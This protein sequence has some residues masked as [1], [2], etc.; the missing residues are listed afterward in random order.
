[1]SLE[2]AYAARQAAIVLLALDKGEAAQVMKSLSSDCL[3]KIT[4]SIWAL[5]DVK[6][7]EKTEALANLTIR[8][9]SNPVVGGEDKAHLLLV[10]VVGEEQAKKIIEKAKKEES[11]R[12]AFRSLLTV[13]SSDLA[14]F[15]IKE[16]PSTIA[17]ILGFLPPEKMAEILEAMDDEDL[18]IEII[19][20]LAS[21]TP[22]KQDTITRIE[23]VFIRDIVSKI[24]SKE[25][26]DERQIGGPKVVA[27]ILQN[28]EKEIGDQ[29]LGAIQDH[30]PDLAAEISNQLFTFED[31]INMSDS[32]M[33]RIMRDVPMD[34]L[35][36]AV[37]GVDPELYNKFAENL[38]KRAKE[39]LAEELEL[40]GKVK[41]SE[42]IAVQR[43]IV[44]LVRSLEAAG[45][46]TINM[47]GGDDE[48]I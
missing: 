6:E 28:S 10:E 14:N 20:K 26:K 37:K 8:L 15:L 45:E 5:D 38:S 2:Q 34:K 42:V 19:L 17:I 22:T 35:P 18:R 44:V 43:E 48:Y 36:T 47:A 1:M 24:A 27:E 33:Q 23:Q 41:L 9:K 7:D 11:N 13:K 32:D 39:N 31:I 46:L 21:P 12:Q 4:Q 30:S 29:L 16:Q 40:M 25:G 3:E